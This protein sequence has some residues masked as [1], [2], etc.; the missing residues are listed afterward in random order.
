LR[1]FIFEFS[2][3]IIAG[4]DRVDEALS[5]FGLNFGFFGKLYKLFERY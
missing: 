1:S 5:S 4:V 2:L 3:V